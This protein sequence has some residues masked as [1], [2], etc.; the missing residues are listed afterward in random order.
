MTQIVKNIPEIRRWVH[1]EQ[2][3]GRRVG[4]VPTM[5]AL[6]R[7]H[8]TLVEEARNRADRVVV[9][10]FVNPLQ[11]G[12]E[13][14]LARYP[15]NL[16]NDFRLLEEQGADVLF[17]PGVE[18]MYPRGPSKTLVE[19]ADLSQVLCGQARPT[20]FRGV[21]TVVAKLFNI[22]R[23][24]VAIFGE[25]DWQQLAVI[26]RMCADLNFP[27]DVVGVPIVREESGLALSSRNQYL[28]DPERDQAAALSRALGL[29]KAQFEAGER[30]REA[31]RQMVLDTLERADITPEYIELTDPDTLETSPNP[32]TGPTLLALAARVGK[33]RLIDNVILGRS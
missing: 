21:T 13:E 32:L 17:A 23:P 24:D 14:D 5:G 12:P 15:R 26:R 22:V 7:G 19:V 3:S 1:G 6:H 2:A 18:E 25:K 30:G 20:H 4:L 10:I 11:F 33:A 31:L 9:S 28:T 8:L 16:E 29:A 27:V